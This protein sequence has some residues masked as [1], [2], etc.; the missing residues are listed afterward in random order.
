M[1]P[2]DVRRPQR[3]GEP[4]RPARGLQRALDRPRS[5]RPPHVLDH[6]A[7]RL[8]L[9]GRSIEDGAGDCLALTFLCGPVLTVVLMIVA[10]GLVLDGATLLWSRSGGMSQHRQ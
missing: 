1:T 2:L 7:P 8:R 4:A 6:L 9:V 10:L 5:P 3:G